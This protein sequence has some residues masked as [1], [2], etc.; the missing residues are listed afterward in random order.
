MPS[1]DHRLARALGVRTGEGRLGRARRPRVRGHRGGSRIRG[2][3]RR[4]AGPGQLRE[5]RPARGPAVPVHGAR[6]DESRRR[7]GLRCRAGT[8]AAR[9]AVR[10]HPRGDRGTHRRAASRAHRWLP[11]DRGR[12]LVDRVRGRDAGRDDVLDGREWLLRRAA[13]QAPLPAAHRRRDRR[14]IRGDPWRRAGDGDRRRRGVD[15]D[16][17]VDAGRGGGAD[18][19]APAPNP[20]DGRPWRSSVDRRRDPGGI[21]VRRPLPVDAP[22]RDRL[23]AAGDPDVLGVLPV[24][25]GR[26]GRVPD[27]RRAR[28]GARAPV[29]GRDRHLIHRVDHAGE[30]HLHEVRGDDGRGR[31]AG[32]LP[33]RV[34]AVAR[35]LLV[36]DRRAGPIRPAGDPA[37]HLECGLE[38]LLQHGPSR[39]AS[40]GHRLQRRGA[41]AGR[42][43]PF[44]R[45]AAGR[46]TIPRRGP[47][48]LAGHRDG[49]GGDRR[50]WAIRR[51]YAGSLLR[52]LRSGGAEQ[53]LEGGP[54]MASL[55]G[56]PTVVE[57][58]LEAARAPE[59]GV[60][61]MAVTVL[62]RA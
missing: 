38:R 5:R 48:V 16:R 33:R 43:H 45:P 14:L 23:R 22:R 32:R 42:D 15:G 30:P 60:R 50:R 3:R 58:L 9:A 34:R 1:V 44:R 62:G 41:R 46:R 26:V 27:G 10:R 24:P 54:G 51:R 31:P 49:P 7:P 28:H 12:A 19:A 25:A 6:R 59:P 2:S 53:V 21:S 56:D 57:A 55:V 37:G 20:R 61:E 11:G 40:P 18:R 39:A 47:G 29:G 13:G 35:Q 17:G 52:A 36:R 4:Y 8:P